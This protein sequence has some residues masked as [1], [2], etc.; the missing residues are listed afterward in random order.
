MLTRAI[1]RLVEGVLNNQDVK[2]NVFHSIHQA[3]L[4]NRIAQLDHNVLIIGQKTCWLVN[5]VTSHKRHSVGTRRAITLKLPG[6]NASQ[7]KL[8]QLLVLRYANPGSTIDVHLLGT[9]SL[10]SVHVSTIRK[11]ANSS[12]QPPGCELPPQSGLRLSPR[13][14]VPIDEA[15][16]QGQQVEGWEQMRQDIIAEMQR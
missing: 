13:I 2:S 1:H 7:W 11:G 3:H 15:S 6:C 5:M 10:N 14:Q 4:L 8:L 9:A 12:F 16:K